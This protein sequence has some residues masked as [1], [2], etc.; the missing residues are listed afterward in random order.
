VVRRMS[1]QL[2]VTAALT[3]F[4]ASGAP[5]SIK[6]QFQVRVRLRG[7]KPAAWRRVLIPATDSLGTLAWTIAVLFGWG[8]DHLHIFK[9]GRNRFT[10]PVLP[11]GGR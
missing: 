10:D 5:C 7:R 3:E 2:E 4:L 6:H 1:S 8:F 11:A 9:I